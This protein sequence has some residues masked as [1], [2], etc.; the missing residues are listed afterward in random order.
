MNKIFFIVLGLLAFWVQSAQMPIAK[1]FLLDAQQVVKNKT[2]IL[3]LFSEHG[4]PYCEVVKEEVLIPISQL[5]EYQQK[6]IVREV[7]DEN[8]MFYDFHHQLTTVSE[9]NRQ[10][11]INFFPTVAILGQNGQLLS[12][13]LIGIVDKEFYW[14]KVDKII[15]IAI[16]NLNNQ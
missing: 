4:C 16:N 6:I 7:S 11:D 2:P 10:Y 1:N 5:P 9:F 15:N 3:V 8:D 13:K 14:Q 12:P